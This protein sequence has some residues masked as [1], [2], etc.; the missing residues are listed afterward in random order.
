MI[1]QDLVHIR[2]LVCGP[3]L[4]GIVRP[5]SLSRDDVD[6]HRLIVRESEADITWLVI[7]KKIQTNEQ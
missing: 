4:Y 6:G 7:K 2:K 1:T 5:L 3:N